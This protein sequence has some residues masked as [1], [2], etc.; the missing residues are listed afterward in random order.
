MQVQL[1]RSPCRSTQRDAAAVGSLLV[2]VALLAAACGGMGNTQSTAPPAAHS[3]H[4]AVAVASSSLGSIVVG[5]NGK[6]LYLFAKD[7]NG[8]SACTGP[9]TKVWPP[10]VPKSPSSG[11][12]PGTRASLLGTMTRTDGTRQ[13]T[14]HGHPLYTYSGD[15][16]PGDVSGQGIDG[17]GAR[18]YVISAQGAAVQK[19]ASSTMTGH[20]Y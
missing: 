5:R 17:F 12:G 7:R 4:S 6:T 20:G 2:L 19:A 18:W 16:K 11:A 3:S 1:R 8:A 13:L 14:Y 15:T 9:C 10:Y